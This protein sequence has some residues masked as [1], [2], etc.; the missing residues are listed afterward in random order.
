MVALTSMLISNLYPCH[1]I[2][3][4]MSQHCAHTWYA[5][6]LAGLRWDSA[7]NKRFPTQRERARKPATSAGACTQF[8][9]E[10]ISQCTAAY[11]HPCASRRRHTVNAGGSDASHCYLPLHRYVASQSAL[12]HCPLQI[13]TWQILLII[14]RS[15]VPVHATLNLQSPLV[16]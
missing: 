12:A 7:L 11:V 10:A 5:A 14:S 13:S 8:R 1:H 15:S 3:N 6:L 16:Q 2:G 4:A 9:T